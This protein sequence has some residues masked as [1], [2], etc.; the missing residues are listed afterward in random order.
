[1]LAGGGMTNPPGIGMLGLPGDARAT[2]GCSGYQGM[3][4]LTNFHFPC[5]PFGTVTL[6]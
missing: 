2:R 1:M 6:P 5:R 3:L 4:G